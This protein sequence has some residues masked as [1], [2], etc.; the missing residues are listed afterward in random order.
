MQNAVVDGI[1]VRIVKDLMNKAFIKAIVSNKGYIFRVRSR[2]RELGARQRH[3]S[4][5]GTSRDCLMR[6]RYSAK[7][8]IER[9]ESK[10]KTTR[11]EKEAEMYARHMQSRKGETA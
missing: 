9:I 7:Q 2:Q 1:N 4:L 6:K 3:L 8:D 10:I 11:Q 5:S